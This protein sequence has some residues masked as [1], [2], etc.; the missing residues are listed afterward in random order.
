MK[1]LS[2]YGALVLSA[3]RLPVIEIG[4]EGQVHAIEAIGFTAPHESPSSW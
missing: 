3:A 2:A 4:P 1:S